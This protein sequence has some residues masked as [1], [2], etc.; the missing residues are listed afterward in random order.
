M[1][2]AILPDTLMTADVGPPETVPAPPRHAGARE[3]SPGTPVDGIEFFPWS[4]QF[5]TGLPEIDAQHRNLVAMLNRLATELAI[6]PDEP[7]LGQVF[8][9]L[10]AYAVGHL[11]HEQ[12]IWDRHLRESP[13]V[14]RHR[15]THAAFEARVHAFAVEARVRPV[16]EVARE[17][18]AYLARWLV[19][20]ILESDRH[21]AHLVLALRSGLSPEMARA[22]ATERMREDSGGFLSVALGMIDALADNTA[23]LV[24]E[25]RDRRQAETALKRSEQMLKRAQ[26]VANVGIWTLDLASG[27]LEWS[28]ETYRMF[29]IPVGET[30]DVERFLSCVPAGDRERVLA[31]WNA[32]LS[33]GVYDVEHRIVVAGGERWI[34]G[35]AQIEL[36]AGGRPLRSIGTVQDVTDR[37]AAH[38]ARVA[39]EAMLRATL[40]AT[41]DGIL[42]VGED[43]RV[44]ATNLR[45][46]ELWRIPAA[47]L[48]RREDQ[49]LLA[50]V[51]EQLEDAPAFLALVQKLYR[52]DDTT[53]D[54]LRFKDGRIFE[55]YTVPLRLGAERA[56]V[57]S[58]RDVTRREKALANLHAERELFIGG[59]VGVLIWRIEEHW[60]LDYASANIHNVFGYTAGQML[61]PGFRY[62]DCIHP[63]DLP[64]V[65]AEVSEYLADA[66][67][68]TWEQHYRIVWPDGRV[69]HLYDF[70]VAERDAG[71]RAVRLRG[72]VTDETPARETAGNLA[73]AREQLQFA[74]EGSGV[75]LWDWNMAT[76]AV[77]LNERWAEMLGHTLDELAPFDVET[78]RRLVHPDDLARSQ[79]AVAAHVRGET[80]RYVCELRV[81]HRSGE[82]L[83]I[84]DQGRVVEWEGNDPASAGP[85]RMVGTMTDITTAK[86]LSE[87]LDH[88][89]GFLKTLVQTV[90]DLVWLK[91]PDGVYLSC[92]TQFE[93]LY[94]APESAIV[95]KTDYDFVS[96]GLADFFRANDRAALA[97]GGP[98]K[99][100][101]W[102]DFPDGSRGLFET[103]KTPMFAPDGRVIGVLGIAHDITEAREQAR[104]LRKADATRY[105]LMNSSH[106]GILIFGED[107]RV[108]EGNP[109][110]AEMLGRTRDELVGMRPWEMD[111]SAT[112]SDVREMRR[113]K[114]L[115]NTRFET[116][117]RRKDGTTYDAEVSV[118]RAEIDGTTYEFAVVRD[119]TARKHADEA[120]RASESQFRA[121]FTHMRLGVVY[122]A[123]DG[124][125]TDA[126]PAACTILG[127]SRDEMLGLTSMTP[128]W[129]AVDEHGEPLAGERHPSMLALAAGQPILD[130]LMGVRHGAGGHTAWIVVSAIPEFHPGESKPF[131][132]F[133]TFDDVTAQ[134]RAALALKT[135]EERLSALLRQAGDGI[136]LIDI[137]TLRFAE[138]NDAACAGLGYSRD[139]FAAL[140]LPDVNR[141]L[142]VEAIRRNLA[143]IVDD[144]SSEFETTHR[145][146]DGSVRHVRV[147]NRPV[148]TGGRTYVVSIWRDITE[149]KRQQSRLD[150]ATAFLEET[151]SIAKVGGWKANPETGELLWTDEVYRLCEHPL[152]TPPKNLEEGLR[153]YAPESLPAVREA[154]ARAMATGEPFQ[155]ECRMIARSG[156]EFWAELR[157][158][159]RVRDPRGTTLTGTFQDVTEARA[160]AEA[161]RDNEERLTYALSG[162]NDGF[163]DWNL[164]TD[165]IYYSPRWLEMLGYEPGGVPG[166]IEAWA[167]LV[168]PDD[169]ERTLSLAADCIVGR[170]DRFEVEFRMRRRD[171]QW[172]HVLSRAKLARDRLG[173]IRKP[174]RLVGTHVDL[175]ERKRIELALERQVAFTESLIDAE[176]DGVSVCRATEAPP[177]VRFTVWNRAMFE[178]TGYTIEEI[179]RLGWYQ[180]VYPDPTTRERA[181]RR[182]DAMR[183]G[184]HLRGEEWTITRKD[185]RSRDVQIHTTFVTSP[186]GE[187]HVLAVMHDV[188]EQKRAQ[189]RL[190][191][192]EARLRHTL[193]NSPNVAVQWYDRDGRVVYWNPASTRLYGWTKEDA[194]GRTLDQLIH[195]PDETAAFVAT[196]AEIDRTGARIGPEEYTTHDRAG[197]RHVVESTIFAIPGDA[198]E[199]KVFVCMDV[200]VTQRKTAEADLREHQNHLEKLVAERTTALVVA[201]EAAEAASIA[202]SA[203]LANMSHEIRTPLNAITG[204]A[205]LIRRGGLTLE[206]AARFAKLEAAAAH[207]LGIINAILEL[208][209][210]EAGRFNL[211]EA[212]VD[213]ES[214]INDV[215]SIIQ[216]RAATKGLSIERAI[217]GLP[218]ALWGDPL[219]LRQAL[220]NY[221]GNAVKFTE[222]GTVSIAAR[223]VEEGPDSALVRF[224]VADTGIGIAPDVLGRLFTAF[225]QADNST[226]RRYGG[227]GLG[228]AITR[229]L[230]QLM[231]GD[232]GAAS[233][234]GEGSRFWFT[235]RLARR[236]SSA[237]TGSP[238]ASTR[239]GLSRRARE[240]RILLVEDEPVNREIV[241]ILLEE[242]GIAY[243]VAEDGA[244]AVELAGRNRYDLILMDMQLPV[245]NGLEATEKI[246]TLPDAR[247]TPIVAMTANAFDEDRERCLAAGMVDFLAKP[248]RPDQFLALVDRYLPPAG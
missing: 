173:E 52:S 208:S 185:G 136:G 109:R 99:N 216:D 94:G 75:G 166:T 195:T 24:R 96:A 226:T 37:I 20:H 247:S 234:P 113:S 91:D 199:D 190:A 63:D 18:A 23:R 43:G 86:R 14:Q 212:P 42:V 188:T 29:G 240:A 183:D 155:L 144:G 213:V 8:D 197:R 218:P 229:K 51:L 125:I 54:T 142:A 170:S 198:P 172:V 1:R 81:R 246:R 110:M 191:E 89:R 235:A 137:E 128:R 11:R 233:A 12:S 71:G 36:D 121:L 156:R 248:F 92:N 129:A 33:G 82:W 90:P 106:D 209:K 164:E 17:V 5:E 154:L 56:R 119:I 35:R 3:P 169:R 178:L 67:R 98:R 88:E 223:V 141:D 245:M 38:A 117:H 202:K 15:A 146:K 165:E 30:I 153:Y 108:L 130:T 65:A 231:G 152:D 124:A 103:T 50:F 151:Q 93:R 179:N 127:L 112:E 203:F 215:V 22:R 180:T 68:R 2:H 4:T 220:L 28:D 149:E 104:A 77:Q 158:I 57:W 72:Y 219:R 69:R 101:E 31:A 243:D 171:G 200:D 64:L 221:A 193:E 159:G 192:S 80:A 232:A 111:A 45:F 114:G 25:V 60:P 59:P 204:M 236:P 107:F 10:A 126:N 41:A 230:A 187:I 66:S 238:L 206:Q 148:Q 87:A 84:L 105:E 147:S 95:G 222:R 78:W 53:F 205:Y 6:A 133:T 186:D 176:V 49:A 174:R 32:A 139:E 239:A 143:R 70:T 79:A 102:L 160:L 73:R 58:F 244:Q 228:L 120:L 44:R 74:I 181:R 62:S 61:T 162:A 115:A 182:M 7:R 214:L 201:K 225:E 39:D 83:W 100:E 184:D 134:R 131:R 177:H 161:L 46:Q 150:E 140:A 48:E 211:D 116:R 167:G 97:A 13:E 19:S 241:A 118:S 21:L 242:R 189:R 196:L 217:G 34:R 9:D 157:C 55:R 85:L 175:T 26:E 27:R 145:H 122:Q 40:D 47:L 16:T 138:F 227:T 210:I 123:A 135:S 194:I 163:W 237:T 168:H 132:V 224:E 207:L 76:G